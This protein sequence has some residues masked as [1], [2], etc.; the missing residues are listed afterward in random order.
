V[1]IFYSGKLA[2]TLDNLNYRKTQFDI[3]D[4]EERVH[5]K[6]VLYV[7]H[8]FS[9]YYKENLTAQQ[10]SNGDT[11][12]TKV[13][14]NFQ[15]LQRECISL[16]KSKHSF[17]RSAPNSIHMEIW[18]PYQYPIDLKHPEFPVAFQLAFINNGDMETRTLILPDNISVLTPGDT[19]R[20][21]SN[22]SIGDLPA[23]IYKMAVCS[24]TGILYN[25]F[26]SN[27]SEAVIS[28]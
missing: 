8:F 7:P 21:E 22:F 15:S 20:V 6:E 1:Y 12:Y 19:I 9:D 10:L 11:I 18:N 26:S 14:K 3:W 2:H 28:D 5:G 4:Y 23:G 17:S 13:F 27:F 24:E 25:T 16:D